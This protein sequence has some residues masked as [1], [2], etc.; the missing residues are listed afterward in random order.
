M[1]QFSQEPTRIEPRMPL[2]A[3]KTYA[4]K[5][6]R[7]THTRPAT[8]E[9]YGCLARQRGWTTKVDVSTDIGR[10]QAGY[11]ERGSGRKW[12]RTDDGTL[13]TYAFEP[14]QECF[15]SHRVQTRPGLYVIRDGDH[16]GNPTG[17][18]VTLGERAWLDDFGE[19]QEKLAAEQERG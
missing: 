4:V 7:A 19:H 15:A 17:R 9:E 8:C 5:V 3:Y 11:I 1:I 6:P 13:L 12:K 10:R 18:K 2:T 16:R 14:G